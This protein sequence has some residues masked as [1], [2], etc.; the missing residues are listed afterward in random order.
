MYNTCFWNLVHSGKTTTEA[1]A[2]LKGT[3]SSDKNELLFSQFHINYNNIPAIY[4]KGS[5]L[6]R[7]KETRTYNYDK[8]TYTTEIHK[9]KKVTICHDDIISDKFWIENKLLGNED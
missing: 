8:D 6:Y 9:K 2:V 1:E 7:S 5:I 4:R 3:F